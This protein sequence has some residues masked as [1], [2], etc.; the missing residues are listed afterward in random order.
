MIDSPKDWDLVRVGSTGPQRRDQPHRMLHDQPVFVEGCD[1]SL[2]RIDEPPDSGR[3]DPM[4]KLKRV[5]S[6][7]V[8][9]LCLT[10]GAR[11][12]GERPVPE[13]D[14]VLIISVD[15]LRPDVMLRASTPVLRNLMRTGSFTMYAET[16]DLA[17][18]LPSHVSMLSGIVP[19]KHGILYNGDTVPEGAPRHPLRPTLFELAKAAGYSTAIVAG[20]HKFRFSYKPGTLDES[21]V[22]VPKQYFNDAEVTDHALAILASKSPQVMLVHLGTTD[23]VGHRMGWGT[24]EQIAT[25]EEADR[26]IGRIVE[27]LD[28]ADLLQRTLLILSAD[29]GGSGKTHGKDDPRSRYIPWI[30]SSPTVP[31]DFDLTRLR[32]LHVRT[33]DTFATACFVLGIPLPDDIEGKPVRALFPQL[34]LMRDVFTTQPSTRSLQ[35]INP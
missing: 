15:G 3:I 32:E 35:V 11:A 8:V 21:V 10:A 7:C 28:K 13:I 16:T 17:V 12:Q 2:W 30:V 27:A 31:Q 26:Q 20:K 6:V 18:T 14:R 9:L 29:H 25:I 23:G 4:P 24:K 34:E 22:P 1:K 19:E 33:E 5:A